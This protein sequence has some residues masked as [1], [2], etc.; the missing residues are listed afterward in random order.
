MKI[1]DIAMGLKDP[2]KITSA[3]DSLKHIEKVLFQL[4]QM[5]IDSYEDKINRDSLIAS[6]EMDL[7]RLKYQ[8]DFIKKAKKLRG[9]S[10]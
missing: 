5:D 9:I 2:N 4:E 1:K 3:E 6:I 8:V 10:E 7:P